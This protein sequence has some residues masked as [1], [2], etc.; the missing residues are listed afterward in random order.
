MLRSA[1]G[2]ARAHAQGSA[3][4]GT[5]IEPVLGRTEPASAPGGGSARRAWLHGALFLAAGLAT[6]SIRS[7]PG[8]DISAHFRVVLAAGAFLAAGSL[9]ERLL[10]VG[11][12]RGRFAFH[13]ILLGQIALIAYFS[14]R[15][16]A[17][18]ALGLPGVTRLELGALVAVAIGVSIRRSL[19]HPRAREASRWTRGEAAWTAA[20][21]L[22]WAAWWVSTVWYLGVRS[23]ELATPSSDP[24]AHAYMAKLAAAQGWIPYDHLPFSPDPLAYPSGFAVLNALWM[25][26]SGLTPVQVVNLQVAIQASL[27]VGLV[28]ECVLALRDR[29]SL[30]AGLWTLA[31]AHFVFVLPGNSEVPWLQGTPRLAHTAFAILF[32]SYALRLG[33]ATGSRAELRAAGAFV[34]AFCAAWAVTTNPAQLV[35]LV[36][37]LVAGFLVLVHGTSAAPPGDAAAVRSSRV[38]LALAFALALL[39]VAS[40]GWLRAL[41]FAPHLPGPP[42]PPPPW[43]LA[44]GWS[45]ARSVAG[46][47]GHYTLFGVVPEAC[48][49]G[50]HCA[51]YLVGLTRALPLLLGLSAAATLLAGAPRKARPRERKP[52]GG[53]RLRECAVAILA[54]LGATWLAIAVCGLVEGVIPDPVT[55][56]LTQ[57]RAYAVNGLRY[58]IPLFFLLL[59]GIGLVAAEGS[60]R[61][62]AAPVARLR[63]APGGAALTL[64]VLAG[65]VAL[66]IRNPGLPAAVWQAYVRDGL[67][68]A[69]PSLGPIEP[70]DLAFLREAEDVVPPGE[71]VLLPGIVT[72]T[73]HEVWNYALASSRALPLY[74]EIHFAFFLGLG[75]AATSAPAYRARVCDAFDVGWLREQGVRW[76]FT[77]RKA[78]ALGG[79]LFNW[80]EVRRACFEE[81]LRRGDR[82]LFRLSESCDPLDPRL[83]PPSGPA[84]GARRGRGLVGFV[85]EC[86]HEAITGWACDRGSEDPITVALELDPGDGAAAPSYTRANLAREPRVA[87][88]CETRS[89]AHGFQLDP[90]S[91]PP[92][93]HAARIVAYDGSGSASRELAACRLVVPLRGPT[94]SE[95]ARGSGPRGHVDGCRAGLIEGWACDAGSDARVMV[96]LRLESDFG[97]TSSTFYLADEKRER[98]V[99]A[100]CGSRSSEHGFVLTPPRMPAGSYSARILAYDARAERSRELKN[101]SVVFEP[102]AAP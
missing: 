69:A 74:S 82:A 99:A 58:L 94:S 11:D 39:I 35:V 21:A 34:A 93:S 20:L 98:R 27:A 66:A 95:A 51:G 76:V 81:R 52:P 80:E 5:E 57:L 22:L 79:C 55:R 50:P 28:L 89:D 71:R 101:C 68:V 23:G 64:G 4:G 96:E 18:H 86:S 24:D 60:W 26:L 44:W 61:R 53:V 49:P 2:R 14:A 3:A 32:L 83:R 38:V 88:R 63:R 67:R 65:L 16:L 42:A 97:A 45:V 13:R 8:S 43:E 92:G 36:P 6:A 1:P 7:A 46:W 41:V 73:R 102:D 12:E 56:N 59:V 25:L 84:S 31:A 40:D 9:L 10:G 77:S 85:D 19:R 29:P 75:P 15:S 78:L 33:S 37:V 54:V 30:A 91:L 90:P 62:I 70:T 100:R 48:L 17:S 72:E 47:L 87:H